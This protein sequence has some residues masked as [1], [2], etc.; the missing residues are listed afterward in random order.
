M[1][2][3]DFDNIAFILSKYTPFVESWG[4]IDGVVDDLCELFSTNESF[5][6]NRFRTF[7]WNDAALKKYF[8]R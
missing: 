1:N 7:I 5:D 6:R 8:N 3:K 2:E 4:D